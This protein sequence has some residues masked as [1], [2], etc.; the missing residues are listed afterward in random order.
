MM[1]ELQDYHSELKDFNYNSLYFYDWFE[2]KF[3]I[4]I[5]KAG[6][7]SCLFL[8]VSVINIIYNIEM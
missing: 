5:K 8:C 3:W 1:I 4:K 2:D 6:N 7:Q